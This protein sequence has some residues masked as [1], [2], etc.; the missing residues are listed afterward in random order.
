MI[1]KKNMLKNE[2]QYYLHRRQTQNGKNRSSTKK[3]NWRILII[4]ESACRYRSKSIIKSRQNR[5]GSAFLRNLL[6]RQTQN[7]GEMACKSNC[8][9]RN[10]IVF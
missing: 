7:D 10:R 1:L 4:L 8:T 3:V 2:D 5:N 9:F 6:I